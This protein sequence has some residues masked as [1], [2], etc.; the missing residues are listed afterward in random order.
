MSADP[1]AI[2]TESICWL[3]EFYDE[4]ACWARKSGDVA[5]RSGRAVLGGLRLNCCV[6]VE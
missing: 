4:V 3:L 5:V 1:L 2:A 6:C